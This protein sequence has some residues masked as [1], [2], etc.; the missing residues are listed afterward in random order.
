[1]GSAFTPGAST[2]GVIPRA[3]D[4]IFA[5]VSETLDAEFTLRVSFV[6]IY[7]VCAQLGGSGAFQRHEPSSLCLCSDVRGCHA[8]LMQQSETQQALT[9]HTAAG[10]H[11]G[12]AGD[13]AWATPI[14]LCARGQE[15]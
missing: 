5:R 15:H 1:M 11:Q 6:E 9:A 8:L 10:R 12:S 13:R 3:M 2:R 14:C 4:D 7:Q